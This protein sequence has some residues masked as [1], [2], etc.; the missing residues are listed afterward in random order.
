MGCAISGQGGTG[1]KLITI[2]F[3]G[4]T[5]GFVGGLDHVAGKEWEESQ[6]LVTSGPGQVGEHIVVLCTEIWNG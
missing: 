6:A 4:R 1:L 5:D 2:C 3:G